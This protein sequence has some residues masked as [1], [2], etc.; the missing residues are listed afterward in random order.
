MSTAI[1]YANLNA[2]GENWPA[3]QGCGGVDED[4]G[5][6]KCKP[7]CWMREGNHR[8]GRSSEPSFHPEHLADPLH[9]R[10]PRRI[11]MNFTGDTFD[12]AISDEQIAAM[13]GIVAACPQHTFLC[14]TKQA[15]RMREWFAWMKR[16]EDVAFRLICAV[17]NLRLGVE[18]DDRLRS[19]PG[20]PLPNLWTGVSVMEPDDLGRVEHLVHCPA[21]VRFVS[22]EPLLGPVDLTRWMTR[23]G[24]CGNHGSV[25]YEHVEP[26]SSLCL[27]ACPRRGEGPDVD[28]VVTAPDS[29]GRM[30][31][32]LDWFRALRDQCVAAGVPFMFKDQRGFPELDGRVWD[33]MPPSLPVAP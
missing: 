15:K 4:G 1:P 7:I 11:L 22:A 5:T 6:L 9:W 20:W 8:W 18:V 29:S 33:E 13:F 17:R 28:W 12:P 14:L 24:E 19:A 16:A 26:G 27:D 2:K 23:C 10:E 21:A 32:D 25:A 30:P 3:V 31:H